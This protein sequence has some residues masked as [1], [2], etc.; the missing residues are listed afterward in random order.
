MQRNSDSLENIRC[1]RCGVVEKA[2]LFHAEVG[3][4][5]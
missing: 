1:E 5:L 4:S 2:E 3:E